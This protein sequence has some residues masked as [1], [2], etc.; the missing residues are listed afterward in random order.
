MLEVKTL[1]LIRE[2]NNSK[3]IRNKV[4]FLV[5]LQ[6]LNKCQILTQFQAKKIQVA[7]LGC[8]VLA[9]VNP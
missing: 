7:K 1:Y 4:L 5:P 2:M 6:S 8:N 9:T 3:N